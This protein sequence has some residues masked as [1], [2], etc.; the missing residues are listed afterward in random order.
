MAAV[1]NPARV[2]AIC[3]GLE[4]L[5]VRP[6]DKSKY[7]AFGDARELPKGVI[8]ALALVGLPFKFDPSVPG[9]IWAHGE[10][11]HPIF[12]CI[13]VPGSLKHTGNL[14]FTPLSN[15]AAEFIESD[16]LLQDRLQEWGASKATI[17]GLTVRQP[18][19]EA[20]ASGRKNIENRSRVLFKVDTCDVNW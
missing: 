13:R 20:I 11:C 6:E 9:S 12:D 1:I 2:I 8:V 16:I 5:D 3:A 14:G 7:S 15:E 4:L 18:A 10:Y 19:A 17:M